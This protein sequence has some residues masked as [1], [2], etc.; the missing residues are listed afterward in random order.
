MRRGGQD[1]N[2]TMQA[3]PS[4]LAGLREKV[5]F[6]RLRVEGDLRL[7]RG[8]DNRKVLG[9]LA[10]DLW[11]PFMVIGH[12]AQGTKGTAQRVGLFGSL[13]SPQS[14]IPRQDSRAEKRAPE[15]L[16]TPGSRK[17]RVKGSQGRS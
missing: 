8:G 9:D 13:F 7:W 11:F 15:R 16:L 10:R 17:Q 3:G 1:I 12:S 6:Y 14:A 5:L 4:D 2:S